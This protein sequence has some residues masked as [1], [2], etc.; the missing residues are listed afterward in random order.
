MYYLIGFI[1]VAVVVFVWRKK[2][3]QINEPLQQLK[4]PLMDPT[5]Q[6]YRESLRKKGYSEAKIESEIEYGKQFA[7]KIAQ[8]M[9]EKEK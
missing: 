6:A 3:Q 2:K 9:Y 5:E 7:Q 8:E 4:K 1:I